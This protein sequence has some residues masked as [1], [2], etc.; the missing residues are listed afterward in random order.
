MTEQGGHFGCGCRNHLGKPKMQHKSRA[1]AM[2]VV[3]R[4]G[5]DHARA[6]RCPDS[7]RWHVTTVGEGI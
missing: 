7:D 6:Y 4:H 3:G 2:E 1:A 5:R